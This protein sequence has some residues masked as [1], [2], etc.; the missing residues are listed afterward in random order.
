MSSTIRMMKTMLYT[1][2]T[3]AEKESGIIVFWDNDSVGSQRQPKLLKTALNY[4]KMAECEFILLSPK[5]RLI[6]RFG[7]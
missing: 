6:R 2:H 5:R 1:L 7:G 3:T 4:A